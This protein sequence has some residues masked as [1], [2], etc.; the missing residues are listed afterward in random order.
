MPKQVPTFFIVGVQRS[1]TTLLSFL[2]GNHPDVFV[3]KNSVTLR[4]LTCI[5]NYH[6]TLPWR[7]TESKE[8]LLAW[9]IRNDYRGRLAQLLDHENLAKYPNI[10]SLVM[11]SLQQ[12]LEANGAKVWGDKAPNLQH[13][14]PDLLQ[15]LPQAKIVH[16]VRDGRA[17]AH[18]IRA[19]AYGNLE[20]SAQTWVDGNVVGIWNQGLLGKENYHLVHYEDLVREP[21]KTTR[22]LCEFLNLPFRPEMLD[23]SQ[24]ELTG[25][26]SSYVGKAFDPSKINRYREL[27]TDKE[28][29]MIERIQGP[30]LRELGYDL[31]QTHREK[32]FRQLRVR[33]RIWLNQKNNLR[34]LFKRKRHRMENWQEQEVNEPLGKRLR[35]WIRLLSLD[36]ISRDIY[37][38]LFRDKKIKKKYF[39]K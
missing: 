12:E 7:G 19:R 13:F 28:V 9:L 8:N 23:L 5:K 1:G 33:R 14:I 31:L 36:L 27:L 18:S 32:D 37:F 34:L 17:V 35:Q 16:V 26:D 4:L 29:R 10:R 25:G 22:E 38:S 11:A 39:R 20:L 6:Q 21:E 24:N 15:L 30:T 2:L 3:G